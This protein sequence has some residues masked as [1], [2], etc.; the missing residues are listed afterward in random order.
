MSVEGGLAQSVFSVTDNGSS[1]L[2]VASSER[3]VTSNGENWRFRR[4]REMRAAATVDTVLSECSLKD[5]IVLT[6]CTEVR[7][8]PTLRVVATAADFQRAAE[9]NQR[10]CGALR[11]DKAGGLVDSLTRNVAAFFKTSR[12]LCGF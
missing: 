9:H 3:G 4:D 10:I 1:G 7:L 6:P 5:L 11:L 12:S 2:P 8:T